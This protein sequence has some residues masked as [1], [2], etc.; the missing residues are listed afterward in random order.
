MSN[1]ACCLRINLLRTA[2]ICVVSKNFRHSLLHFIAHV[3]HA[4]IMNWLN[5]AFATIRL[6]F[7]CLRSIF[8]HAFCSFSCLNRGRQLC[9]RQNSISRLQS[10]TAHLYW[11]YRKCSRYCSRHWCI[12]NNLLCWRYYRTHSACH[13]S[14]R[15]RERPCRRGSHRL[16]Y[17]NRTRHCHCGRG[18]IKI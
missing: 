6:L 8:S 14:C 1:L 15:N 5:Y 16:S 4:R 3:I 9:V 7:F 11:R 10:G 13:L 18:L 17:R 12:W 2:H